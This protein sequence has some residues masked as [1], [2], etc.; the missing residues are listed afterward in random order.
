M[1]SVKLYATGKWWCG[2]SNK[3]DDVYPIE[4]EGIVKEII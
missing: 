4:L 2:I 3:Y 1:C